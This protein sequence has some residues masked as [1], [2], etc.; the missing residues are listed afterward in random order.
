[1]SY[2]KVK[3]QRSDD[4]QLAV[5]VDGCAEDTF[6]QW[7]VKRISQ[8]HR[9]AVDLFSGA[10]GLSLGLEA[11]GWTV[12][13]SVDNDPKALQTHRHNFAGLALGRD[14]S[15]RD[16]REA[17]ITLL[18]KTKIDLL[19]GGP[20]C[21]PF[22]RAGRSKIRSLVAAGHREEHDHRRELWQAFLDV[23]LAVRPRAVLMENVPDMALGD[24][25]STVRKMADALEA[26]G[27]FTSF[28]L[29][30]AWKYGVPQ[31]RKRLILLARNDAEN[32]PWPEA[33]SEDSQP[34][35]RDA[36]GDLPDLEDT[37]GARELKYRK[38]RHLPEF[39][40]RMRAGARNGVVWD[41]MTRP[42]REDDR[43]IFELMDAT[44]LY[45]DVPARLRRYK[46]E[47]FDDKYK[48]LDWGALSRSITAHIAKDGYWYI[49]PQELRTLTVREAARV[50]TFPDRFRFAGT[51]SDAFRQIGNAVPPLLGQAAATALVPHTGAEGVRGDSAT[52]SRFV[53]ARRAIT[54]WAEEQRRGSLWHAYPNPEVT[55]T[56]AAV[57]AVL[58][59][60]YSRPPG[61]HRSL[62]L[63][64][65]KD[66][67]T[68]SDLDGMRAEL[69]SVAAR[70]ALERF[71]PLIGKRLV[72][73][74][75]DEVVRQLDLKPVEESVF[76][77]LVGEDVLLAS[78]AT[79]RVA[80]RV[81][82][83]V[84]DRANR[85]SDGRVDLARLVGAGQDA[86]LRAAA[87]RQIGNSICRVP[88]PSCAECPLQRHCTD[89]KPDQ[90]DPTL[91]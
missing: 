65:G 10:G 91:F 18:K 6:E 30:D 87:L 19:A 54:E 77:M 39:A 5:H 47:T 26:A 59:G 79:L 13:V 75:T 73:A 44:T 11:A 36:I 76:R 78:Q 51:R 43:E 52:T 88:V 89:A 49:H 21:Q 25:F 55:P 27:Y 69:K 7:C 45:A 38:P 20:P 74:D 37:T 70:N 58:N 2:Y 53:L 8:G 90:A 23:V 80:A 66:R 72:W 50:Q 40:Q 35:L 24:D 57:S 15:D 63:I 42:V 61:F 14:L 12:A 82:G 67:L 83:T 31:H 62:E 60:R 71:Q 1:M 33:L 28:R 22:S 29:V 68:K 16:E 48:K 17:L 34:T 41:H 85:L 64:R 9:L 32:F 84:S 3:L 81:S 46:V 56:V 86:P 4:L